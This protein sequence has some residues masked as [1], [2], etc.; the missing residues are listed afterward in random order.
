M[1]WAL[2]WSQDE[3]NISF[4]VAAVEPKASN[5]TKGLLSEIQS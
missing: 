1:H 5:K 2:L 4:G 3:G